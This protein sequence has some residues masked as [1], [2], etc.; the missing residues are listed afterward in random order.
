MAL[1]IDLLLDNIGPI[2]L[3]SAFLFFGLLF[4]AYHRLYNNS[5][6]Q[7]PGKIAGIEK[8]LSK[9]RSGNRRRS[10]LMYRPVVSFIYRGEKTYFTAG[11]SKNSISD[12]IGERVQVEYM[13]DLI[14][15]VRIAGRPFIRN[16][17]YGFFLTGLL[18]LGIGAYSSPLKWDLQ[19]LQLSIPFALNWIVF[20]YLA[21]L[22]E[23]HGGVSALMKQNSPIKT[24]DELQQLD[25]FWSNDDIAK[26][27]DRVYKPFLYITPVLIGLAL[28]P[29]GVFGERFFNQSYVVEHFN[30][31][32]FNSGE[33]TIFFNYIMNHSALQKEFL[34]FSMSSFFV[35]M[36]S[37]SFIFTLKKTA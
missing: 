37:Y 23:R 4:I 27:E 10:Q 35:L 14:S 3:A 29:A 30:E 20:K 2:L 7:S 31:A 28:W 16:F 26:E 12:Q 8:Y 15:S 6:V 36:L 9:S 5:S 17:G 25:I 19:L 1:S 11:I 34:I 18:I 32:L 24:E 22:F 33:V 13:T 21:G